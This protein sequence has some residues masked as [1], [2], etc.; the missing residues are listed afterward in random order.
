MTS[1]RINDDQTIA[2]DGAHQNAKSLFNIMAASNV[3]YVNKLDLLELWTVLVC[4]KSAPFPLGAGEAIYRSILQALSNNPHQV[5]ANGKIPD[6]P[7]GDLR[8]VLVFQAGD[9][10]NAPTDSYLRMAKQIKSGER[11]DSY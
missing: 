2:L 11:V 9:G 5:F 8:K 10:C 3:D 6:V 1:I 7:L 4:V